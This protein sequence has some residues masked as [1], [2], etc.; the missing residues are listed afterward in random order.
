[1]IL[2]SAAIP[3]QGGAHHVNEQWPEY[4]RKKFVDRNYTVVDCIR[5]KVWNDDRIAVWYAQNT[6]LYVRNDALGRYPALIPFRDGD[7]IFSAVHPRF[8]EFKLSTWPVM[9]AL[10]NR[11][12]R[13]LY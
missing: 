7:A 4:W 12:K 9:K 8:Y 1:V 13:F 10:R 11:L 2:F 3:L 5:P 6:F